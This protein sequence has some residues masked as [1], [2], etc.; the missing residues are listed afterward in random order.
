MPPETKWSHE[1]P[2]RKNPA[3]RP[4]ATRSAAHSAPAPAPAPGTGPAP[5]S[6]AAAVCAA[7][8][9][10]P[11]GATTAIIADAAGIGRPATR[12]VLTAMETA[13]TV[14][15]TKGGKPGIP[16]TW[17]LT[18]PGH[19]ADHPGPDQDDGQAVRPGAPAASDQAS[20]HQDEAADGTRHDGAGA[21]GQHD[22]DASASAGGTSGPAAGQAAQP[23]DGPADDEP[24]GPGE[25]EPADDTAPAGDSTHDDGT[26]PGTS[27]S[28]ATDSP[29]GGAAPDPALV[30]EITGQ[31]KQ[32][33]AAASAAATV[34]AGGGDL[35]AV[36]AG[37]D[38]IWEQAAQARRVLKAAAGGKKTPAARPGALR[39]KILG[40]L[41]DHPGSDFTPHEIHK[42]LG[43]SSGAIANALD[44]LVKHGQ[45]ELASDK[46]RRFRLAPGAPAAAETGTSAETGAADG[47]DGD[48]E[49]AGAA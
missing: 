12:E 33:Q 14:T 43:N 3:T 48:A 31:V 23:D 47:T 11:G 15:R 9:A 6:P 49:L 40:H 13:G 27:D 39:D 30:A 4:A 22:D 1:M 29:A 35:S 36:R 26:G 42:V 17:T 21:P 34:L 44:T 46:P 37:M 2:R 41:R 5:D 10:H 32:I 20:P 19:A 18:A 45:A 8:T 38:E 7:L 25:E 16:D 28:T 24:D